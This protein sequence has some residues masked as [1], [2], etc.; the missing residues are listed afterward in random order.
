MPVDRLDVARVVR[1]VAFLAVFFAD[2]RVVFFA[3]DAERFVVERLAVDFLAVE[4]LA[5]C[6]FLMLRFAAAFCLAV[7]I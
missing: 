6:A 1:L 2:F 4:R 7:A 3:G 5:A